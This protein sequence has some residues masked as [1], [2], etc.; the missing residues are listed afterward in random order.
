[1]TI[2]IKVCLSDLNA[3]WSTGSL[4][5]QTSSCASGLLTNACTHS[6]SISQPTVHILS[7]T[8]SQC[9]ECTQQV[10]SM[11]VCFCAEHAHYGMPQWWADSEV[12]LHISYLFSSSWFFS[13]F[14]LLSFHSD[15]IY[16]FFINFNNF[17]NQFNS[18]ICTSCVPHST[19][20]VKHV[21]CLKALTWK[22]MAQDIYLI[23]WSIFLGPCVL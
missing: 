3:K 11:C 15:A 2:F 21:T 9:T 4:N 20:S 18:L 1:M 7:P 19:V 8:V 22:N 10:L 16:A 23:I 6:Q 13:S 12:H 17:N 14:R 5:I